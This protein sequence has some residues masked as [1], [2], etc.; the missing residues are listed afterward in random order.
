[1]PSPDIRTKPRRPRVF[2][3]YDQETLANPYGLPGRALLAM[4]RVTSGLPA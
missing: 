3:D 4:M 1:M 2:L